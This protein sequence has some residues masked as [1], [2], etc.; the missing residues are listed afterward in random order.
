MSGAYSISL[1]HNEAPLM[2]EVREEDKG[3]DEGEK[4]ERREGEGRVKI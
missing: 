4:E 2:G 3:R 1:H